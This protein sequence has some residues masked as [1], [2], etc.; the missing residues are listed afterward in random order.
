ML[1]GVLLVS[2]AVEAV[3]HF[4]LVVVLAV[5]L[6]LLRLAVATLK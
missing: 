4:D 1:T 5:S 6:L 3:L 2:T